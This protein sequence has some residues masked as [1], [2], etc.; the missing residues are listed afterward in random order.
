MS[1]RGGGKLQGGYNA[2]VPPVIF[3]ANANPNLDLSFRVRREAGANAAL[4]SIRYNSAAPGDAVRLRMLQTKTV[5]DL[6]LGGVWTE[7]L[8]NTD[9]DVLLG[10][11]YDVFVRANGD[12]IQVWLGRLDAG[13]GM[14]KIFD[15][16]PDLAAIPPRPVPA[17]TTSNLVLQADV[18]T[19][20]WFDNIE[21][22]ANSNLDKFL[23]LS[24]AAG[25]L[26]PCIDTG[27]PNLPTYRDFDDELGPLDGPE[28]T[29]D[30][31][32]ESD[33]GADEY[34]TLSPMPYWWKNF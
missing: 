27:K 20:V 14:T 19:T 31:D 12:A 33:I 9:A 17:L 13:V 1:A 7:A 11:W 32:E 30:T 18:G 3:R 26:S 10:N 34:T 4:V 8:T 6:R 21:L 24:G 25:N 22:D 29:E 16:W 28:I 2:T 5:L 15:Y 23:K